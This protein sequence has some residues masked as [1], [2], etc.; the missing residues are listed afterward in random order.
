MYLIGYDIAN[1]KRL[2]KVYKVMLHYATPIQY[3]VFLF[4]GSEKMLESCVEEI[5]N[6]INKKEDD[7]RLYQLPPNGKQWRLGKSFLPEGIFLTGM[8]MGI[9]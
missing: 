9:Y 5:L 1:P 3:S 2:A 7:F 6:L 4:E 8:P